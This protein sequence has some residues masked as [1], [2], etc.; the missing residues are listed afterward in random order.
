MPKKYKRKMAKKRKLPNRVNF[1]VGCYNPSNKVRLELKPE[2]DE[3]KASKKCPGCDGKGRYAGLRVLE[4]PCKQCGGSGKVAN[5]SSRL[6]D[7]IRTSL[8]TGKDMMVRWFRDINK[9]MRSGTGRNIRLVFELPK[10]GEK[11]PLMVC[12]G[13]AP[14][15]DFP[16]GWAAPYRK[17]TKDE[18]P[19][20]L[21]EKILNS[22]ERHR[23]VKQITRDDLPP[24]LRD[25]L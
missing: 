22:S 6:P 18:S 9:Y 13:D 15:Q 11:H 4:D 3:P 16:L 5:K 17:Y 14:D 1:G 12:V 21:S 25:L 23:M 10:N 24:E 7:D 20:I 19:R 8:Y 2:W